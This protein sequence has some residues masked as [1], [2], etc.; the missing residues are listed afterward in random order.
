MAAIKIKRG[1]ILTATGIYWMECLCSNKEFYVNIKPECPVNFNALK[2][3]VVC[4][5][6]GKEEPLSAILEVKND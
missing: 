1:S 6:C 2:K 5:Y 4:Q 3:C